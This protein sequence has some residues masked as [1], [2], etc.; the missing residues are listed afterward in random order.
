MHPSLRLLVLSGFALLALAAGPRAQAA[1]CGEGM[2]C[3]SDPPSL[4]RV[5]EAGGYK[6]QWLRSKVTGNPMISSSANGYAFDIYFYGCVKN[7]DCTSL[8]FSTTFRRSAISSE[9]LA[10]DWNRTNRF[11]QMAYDPDTG[12]MALVYD[13][14]TKGGL[15]AANFA[16]VLDWWVSTLANLRD[17]FDARAAARAVPGGD[18]GAERGE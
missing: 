7:A 14:T 13:V 16:D 11:G 6:T 2:V 1:D 3:A 9:E 8:G 10:N 4:I 12:T 5:L 17:F 18:E 15:P